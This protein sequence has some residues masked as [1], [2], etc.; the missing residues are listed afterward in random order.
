MESFTLQTGLGVA[1]ALFLA[2]L[3][4]PPE[5]SS[6]SQGWNITSSRAIIFLA[7]MGLY[8]FTSTWLSL[9]TRH[10]PTPYLDEVFH[11]PQAL[12]YC[13]GKFLEWDDKITTPPGLYLVSVALHTLWLRAKCSVLTLR[14]LN[15][16]A[17]LQTVAAACLSRNLLERQYAS[18]KGD[19]SREAGGGRAKSGATAQCHSLYAFHTALN[20]GLFPVLF[21]FSALYYTDVYSSFFVLLCYHNHLT[22][23]S[24][25]LGAVPPLGSG[26]CTVFLGAATLWFRQTNIFWVVVYMGGMEAVFA[27]KGLRPGK[28]APPKFEAVMDMGK[29]YAWR[30]ALGDVHDPPLWGSWP[31][32][33]V[34]S[35]LSIGIAAICNPVRVWRQMWPYI[36][37]MAM[38]VLFVGWNGSVVLGDKSNHVATLHLAQMLYIWPLFA[39]FSFPLFLPRLLFGLQI[40]AS[41]PVGIYRYV[42]SQISAIVASFL[43]V[44]T[45][46]DQRH[47]AARRVHMLT[48]LFKNKAYYPFAVVGTLL[49]TLLIIKFNTIVHPFTLA[50]NRHYMFYV[51]RLFIR[52]SSTVR[53]ALAVPYLLCAKLCWQALA[54]CDPPAPGDNDNAGASAG[55]RE[56]NFSETNAAYLSSPFTSYGLE[57]AAG[58][59]GGG[60]PLL[61]ADERRRA[62]TTPSAPP[63]TTTLLG[64]LSDRR[65]STSTTAPATS[66]AV[67][68]LLA[69]TL[70]LITAPLVEPRYFILPWVFWR[71]LVPAWRAHE[72][73]SQP[74]GGAGTGTLR[75]RTHNVLSKVPLLGPLVDRIW[76]V[77]GEVDVRL[78]VET[79]WFVAVNAV[80]M[81]IF[82]YK[83]YIWRDE[84][85]QVLDAGR[86][87]RF[88]W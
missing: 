9:V 34:I 8:N 66:T 38:F 15:G 11:I 25:R 41:G 49:L 65:R 81:W 44:F 14:A 31:D 43:F 84:E 52:R 20:I 48:T 22:R 70:S 3:H 27:V 7:Y 76:K 21:F 83:G 78:V 64:R 50:D 58:A 62:S 82:L 19:S 56:C 67:L 24:V 1:I 5:G 59:S 33:W 17:I 12:K 80:T 87:Q 60:I 13:D 45:P 37:V 40:L 16:H 32:D 6:G 55:S 61:E 36:I 79:I 29:W 47:F 88:M 77:G 86:T 2:Y 42:A 51:F 35:L 73:I 30:W 74:P 46:A 75:V 57:R 63:S 18:A 26:V 85:G 23:T 69:T 39:F 53:L 4:G 72:C 28:V 71:V 10:V 68:W 54:G